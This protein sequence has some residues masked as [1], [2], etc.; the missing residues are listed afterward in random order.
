MEWDH[1]SEWERRRR[2]RRT[3]VLGVSFSVMSSAISLPA[4]FVL[5]MLH[6]RNLALFA[7]SIVT[8]APLLLFLVPFWLDVMSS[9]WRTR[10][11]M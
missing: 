5:R 11:Q 6:L 1:L 3:F 8:I 9:K 10:S 2:V 7:A 4:Y